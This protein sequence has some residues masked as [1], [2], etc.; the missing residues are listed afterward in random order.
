MGFWAEIP[1]IW[2]TQ[3]ARKILI[4]WVWP[5][6]LEKYF[7]LG[8]YYYHLP[9]SLLNNY[10]RNNLTSENERRKILIV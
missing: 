4:V 5:K 1:T 6:R 8:I 9:P 3:M 7:I 10:V 2:A